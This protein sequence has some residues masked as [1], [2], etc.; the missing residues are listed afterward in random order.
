MAGVPQMPDVVS[1]VT[2]VRLF[3]GDAKGDAEWPK[4]ADMADRSYGEPAPEE[5]NVTQSTLKSL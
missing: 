3:T 1:G 2:G 4:T 5:R